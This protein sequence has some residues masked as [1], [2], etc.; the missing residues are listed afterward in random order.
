MSIMTRSEISSL[1]PL[2]RCTLIGEL[3]DSL[4]NADLP[5]TPAQCAELERRLASFEE[6]RAKA[7]SW[8]QLK[9]ELI[10]RCP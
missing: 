5:L 1:T 2:E 9:A 3:W 6:D 4:D 7:V 8:E 10:R